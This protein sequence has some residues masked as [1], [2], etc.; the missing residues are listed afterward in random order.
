MRVNPP[1]PLPVQRALAKL[2]A[3]V[4]VVDPYVPDWAETPMLPIEDLAHRISDFPLS[5]VVTN[6]RDFDFQKIADLAP[7]V[8]DCRNA[9]PPAEQVVAL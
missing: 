7:L 3:K 4:T 1:I 6:H 9:M 2:G 5:I 8:L